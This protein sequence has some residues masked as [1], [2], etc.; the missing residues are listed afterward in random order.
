ML[1]AAELY[2]REVSEAMRDTYLEHCVE[3]ACK[4]AELLRAEGRQPWIGRLRLTSY[5]GGRVVHDAL[6][7]VRFASLTWTTHYVACAG[8]TAFDPLAGA[9]VP[10]DRYAALVF[11]RPIPVTT[12]LDVGSTEALLLSGEL[13]KSFA[14]RRPLP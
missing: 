14:P 6:I 3:H 10:L 5:E 11:G 12:H 7:P 1:S 9:P 13:R 8:T 4:L 2:V